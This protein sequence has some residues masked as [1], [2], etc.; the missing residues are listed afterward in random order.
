MPNVLVSF[1]VG[2][3]AQFIEHLEDECLIDVIFELFLRCFPILNLPRPK[4]IIR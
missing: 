3:H 2:Y 4:Q 1:V